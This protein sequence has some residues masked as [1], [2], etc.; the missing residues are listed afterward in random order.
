[1]VSMQSSDR[2]PRRQGTM[3]LP[4]RLAVTAAAGAG[5][6]SALYLLS[7]RGPALLIDLSHM[8]AGFLCF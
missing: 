6:A 7:E 3:P 2:A 1:M 4:A 8:A 5:L